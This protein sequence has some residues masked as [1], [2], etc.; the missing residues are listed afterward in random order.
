MFLPIRIKVIPFK[1]HQYLSLFLVIVHVCTF[2]RA[3]QPSP[4]QSLSDQYWKEIQAAK[5]HVANPEAISG[6]DRWRLVYTIPSKDVSEQI[7]RVLFVEKSQSSVVS[8]YAN[9][10]TQNNLGFKNDLK[11]GLGL[12]LVEIGMRRRCKDFV[13]PAEL[14]KCK[15]A[16]SQL[17]KI[18][19]IK[20]AGDG[21]S[22]L[23]FFSRVQE[24]FSQPAFQEQTLAFNA[25]IQK[26]I[27]QFTQ[28]PKFHLTEDVYTVALKACKGDS[29]KAVEMLGILTSRDVLVTRYLKHLTADNKEFI[30]AFGNLSLRI[31]LVA[32]LDRKARN[33]I[34]DVF[35]FTNKFSTQTEKNYYYW[36]AAL[37]SQEL[38]DLGYSDQLISK[39]AAELPRQYKAYRYLEFKG[40]L[41]SKEWL[42]EFKRDAVSTMNISAHGAE[43]GTKSASTPAV[44]DDKRFESFI[45][46]LKEKKNTESLSKIRALR[47]MTAAKGTTTPFIQILYYDMAHS[48]IGL[49][50]MKMVVDGKVYEIHRSTN[51]DGGYLRDRELV[52]GLTDSKVGVLP[53]GILELPATEEQKAK[54]IQFLQSES[55]ADMQYSYFNK[56][57]NRDAYNCGGI[58]YD[59]LK[60][61]GYA[62]PE[63]PRSKTL[64]S[65]VFNE[66]T[67]RLPEGRVIGNTTETAKSLL[68][69]NFSKTTI[70]GF[71]PAVN[72]EF[73][74]LVGHDLL[75]AEQGFSDT[76]PLFSNPRKVFGKFS[77]SFSNTGNLA[78]EYLP[79]NGKT[80]K[81]ITLIVPQEEFEMTLLSKNASEFSKNILFVNKDKKNKCVSSFI[82]MKLDNTTNGSKNFRKTKPS[83][84][85]LPARLL[86]VY[87]SSTARRR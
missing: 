20:N 37:A 78:E 74:P 2:A 39:L 6:F 85:P 9:K 29:R 35:S 11:T 26:L 4:N 40:P 63:L 31:R 87:M 61:G 53:T 16:A 84:L 79:K 65:Q 66:I 69:A 7:G 13:S 14:E 18:L 28:N 17:I 24:R 30:N 54:M 73:S 38:K 25:E 22:G 19:D 86:A 32:D 27:D 72:R 42:K 55:T 75:Q 51:S 23:P 33:S 83:G 49:S 50:H 47:T 56:L 80:M 12:N 71:N 1:V 34:D 58:M 81:L 62:L 10:I 3:E 68:H 60:E 45:S 5:L 64:A 67:K 48:K 8:S 36:S 70:T 77:K 21:F 46:A 15:E 59:A 57:L 52:Q 82:P 44:S 76:T 41:Q 43:V